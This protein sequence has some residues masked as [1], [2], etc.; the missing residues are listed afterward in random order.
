MVEDY[1]P[2]SAD[3]LTNVFVSLEIPSVLGVVPIPALVRSTAL[4]FQTLESRSQENQRP[5]EISRTHALLPR[6]WYLQASPTNGS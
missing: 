6:L 2:P 3:S 5:D 4:L 1:V